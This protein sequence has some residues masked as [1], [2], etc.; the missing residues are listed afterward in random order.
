MS[1]VGLDSP[2][3]IA[4]QSDSTVDLNPS[5]LSLSNKGGFSKDGTPPVGGSDV[6][7]NVRSTPLIREAQY[8]QNIGLRSKAQVDSWAD[9]T[10]PIGGPDLIHCG[11]YHGI[12][13]SQYLDHDFG[14]G[15]NGGIFTGI[16]DPLSSPG[17]RSDDGY[18]GYY[19]YA[20]GVDVSSESNIENYI[21]KLV[22]LEKTGLN[23]YKKVDED[24]I[25]QR[26]S[27][28]M[29]MKS[30]KASSSTGG[31]TSPS[32]S[33]LSS[34]AS[35]TTSSNFNSISSSSKREI[36]ITY[37]TYNIFNKS[38]FRARYVINLSKPIRID[39]SFQIINANKKTHSFN[40]ETI[41]TNLVPQYWEELRASQLVRLFADLDDPSRQ[42]AGLVSF[43]DL[44]Q[45]QQ[46]YF[47]SIKTLIK[48]LPKGAMTDVKKQ[49]GFSSGWGDKREGYSK[50]VSYKNYLIDAL[51][52]L[53]HMDGGK[54]CQV[55]LDE[56]ERLYPAS[57]E[58]DYVILQ[59]LKLQTGVNN[60]QKF[61]RLIHKHISS[62]PPST[63]QTLVL[64]EQVKFLLNKEKYAMALDI[65]EKCIKQ[66]P[67][68]F[69]CWFILA[70]CYLLNSQF[71]RALSIINSLPVVLVHKHRNSD[72]DKISGIPD[73]FTNTFINRLNENY[74]EVI[75]ERAFVEYFPKPVVPASQ[76]QRFNINGNKG[77]ASGQR[78]FVDQGSINKMWNELFVFDPSTRHPI[79]GNQ[80]YQS[81]LMNA[82][83]K[84]LSS[85][86]PNLIR[87]YGPTS[88][89]L[90]L[91]SQSSGTSNSSLID[92]CTKSTW[93]RCYDLLSLFVG[94]VGWDELVKLKEKVFK[95]SSF[96]EM[97]HKNNAEMSVG[98]LIDQGKFQCENWLDQLFLILY[99]DLKTLMSITAPNRDQQHS[100]L[101][102][103]MLGFLGWS[104]KFN[105]EESICALITSVKGKEIVGGFDYFGTVK[106]LQI[107]DEFILSEVTD[108]QI[109]S[110]HDIYEGTFLS[111]KLLIKKFGKARHSNF[112]KDLEENLLNLDFVLLHLMKL[113]SWNLRWYSYAPNYLVTKVLTKLMIKYDG[114]FIRG[115]LRVVFEQNKR[116]VQAKSKSGAKW[117]LFSGG[118]KEKKGA[119]I[120]E[121]IEGDTIVDYVE[122]LLSW[123]ESLDIDANDES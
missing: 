23:E 42:L 20:N 122:K 75:S 119:D 77:S 19:H 118:G 1:S 58:W 24:I 70:L 10:F 65:A 15:S 80:F 86:D 121:F 97:E 11:N 99:D 48:F 105:L 79:T 116:Q 93:G 53:C 117:F 94:L 101:E 55:A 85:V 60:E 110:Y 3:S 50:T 102:W 31:P 46:Q 21:C 123:I 89:K 67:L 107:Y 36:L 16:E 113:I 54:G 18:V 88:L 25:I 120:S 95:Q 91:S 27:Q 84:E 35:T 43:P 51:L 62:S 111:N 96:K 5:V 22:G 100:A 73:L 106:L 59:I 28:R 26:H 34:A 115:K 12:R 71:E 40:S 45:T 38:D 63:Q 14:Q 74:E 52:R 13:S 66:L 81:P 9:K 39:K 17:K 98:D 78:R 69:D 87:I 82:S 2:A 29:T 41:S 7:L 90:I 114:I 68:D 61:I 56:I 64:L 30:R 83:A 33:P 109:D 32:S 8:G 37:C 49:H 92:F 72:S 47:Q 112:I 104:V 108:S 4:R 6:N 103:E 44:L 57:N 76:Y